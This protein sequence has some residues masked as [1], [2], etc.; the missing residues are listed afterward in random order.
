MDDIDTSSQYLNMLGEVAKNLPDVV[1]SLNAVSKAFDTYNKENASSGSKQKANGADVQKAVAA[2]ENSE[3]A[4]AEGVKN[5]QKVGEQLVS[6]F[7]KVANYAIDK[8][9]SAAQTIINDYNQNLT[10]I[11]V[12]MGQSN[13]QYTQM[14]N[15]VTDR[16][17]R[18]G[19][20]RQF[21][22]VD[23]TEKLTDVLTLGLRGTQ[24]QDVAYQNMI[25]S[26]LVPALNTNTRTYTRASKLLGTSF[27][28]GITAITK[29]AEEQYGGEGIENGTLNSMIE[30]FTYKILANNNG[31]DPMEVFE[32]LIGT[33]SEW[34]AR[35]SSPEAVENM[36]QAYRSYMSGDKNNVYAMYAGRA[37][38]VDFGSNNFSTDS[39]KKF[40]EAYVN[41]AMTFVNDNVG[42]G[43]LNNTN[44]GLDE[45]TYDA[46]RAW[47]NYG[48]DLSSFSE[49]AK[50]VDFDTVYSSYKSQ[51]QGG[52]YQSIT[53][54][55]QKWN[56]NAVAKISNTLAEKIPDTVTLIT[57]GVNI[58]S[59]FYHAWAASKAWEEGSSLF[60]KGDPGKG[61]PGLFAPG[62][63]LALTSSA[64]GG[65]SVL[66][67]LGTVAS[68]AS[69]IAGTV[70]GV[71]DAGKAGNRAANNGQAWLPAAWRG[72]YTGSTTAGLTEEE[73]KQLVAE[74]GTGLDWSAVGHNALKFGLI[75]GGAGALIGSAVPGAGTGIG[76]GVGAFAGA[77]YGAVSNIIDQYVDMHHYKELAEAAE[78]ASESLSALET[79]AT[80]YDTVMKSTKQSLA[81]LNVVTHTTSYSQ[82]EVNKAFANLKRAYPQYIG[83]I[84]DVNDLDTTYI[85]ILEDKIEL[86]KLIASRD[87]KEAA[88]KATVD[89]GAYSGILN[90]VAEDF[91]REMENDKSLYIDESGVFDLNKWLTG[92]VSKHPNMDE[93]EV[94]GQLYTAY[95]RG[96]V[97]AH[98]QY[99]G[100]GNFT[101]NYYTFDTDANAGLGMSAYDYDYTQA[102]A[103]SEEETENLFANEWNDKILPE[104]Y[105][106]RQAYLAGDTATAKILAND[107]S[108]DF[109]TFYDKVESNSKLK[110]MYEKNYKPQIA[111]GDNNL[112][113]IFEKLEMTPPEF[114]VGLYDVTM[115]N[116]LARLHRGEMVLTRDQAT[117]LRALAAAN[118]GNVS[119]LLTELYNESNST[120]E[121]VPLESKVSSVSSIVS[122]IT[123]QT[124]II[125]SLL[126][127][128]ITQMQGTSET[129]AAPSSNIS[130]SLLN[131]S[132]V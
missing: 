81:D 79:A 24:A 114:R 68:V 132:G 53:A 22:Q 16:I 96:V 10:Q 59:D 127:V 21:S 12:R 83:N 126:N 56:E 5:F 106:L 94:L 34:A 95:G 89:T 125:S 49:L 122:A 1:R 131:F 47:K 66:T 90:S 18:D 39:F 40:A 9:T 2:L 118:G 113:A 57:M 88:E 93:Q 32:D 102:L 42:A 58:L 17:E 72:F 82:E 13:R 61:E 28:Q 70:M 80:D 120:S 116:S 74:Q 29:F 108:S 104:F 8:F 69:I 121:A 43:I 124:E 103:Q 7:S 41:G 115:D 54:Q 25:T 105:N 128:I 64:E 36:M 33:T 78:K 85:A 15:D 129:T 62:G 98:A 99:D 51:L 23:F 73:K 3:K 19:L 97:N 48:D 60:G 55:Q 87:A 38:G 71:V 14:L 11:T 31:L 67:G 52:Q 30:T 44:L 111:D 100:E 20:K 101:G 65:G 119:T 130:P 6:A 35:L 123:S 91:A 86:E 45:V 84:E 92:Y 76:A 107:L 46:I 26:K 37:S 63:K 27:S 117:K 112:K 75:G 110:A 109:T 77:A 50:N 4:Q